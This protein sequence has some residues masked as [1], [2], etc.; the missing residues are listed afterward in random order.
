M[1]KTITAATTTLVTFAVAAAAYMLVPTMQG[2]RLS[3]NAQVIEHLERARRLLVEAHANKERLAVVIDGLRAAGVE[4]LDSDSITELVE[5]DPE[6]LTGAEDQLGAIGQAVRSRRQR[7]QSEANA[8]DDVSL[9][10][11]NARLGNN[12][13]QMAQ[14]ISSG[15]RARQELFAANESVLEE[16]LRE[17][18]AALAAQQG[19]ATGQDDPSALRLLGS[20]QYLQGTSAQRRAEIL[21]QEVTRMRSKLLTLAAKASQQ[22]ALQGIASES[23]I[24]GR[25]AAA[26]ED[27]QEQALHLGELKTK[28]DSINTIIADLVA[29]LA[30]QNSI[31]DAARAK[32]DELALRDLP[33]GDAREYELFAA[34]YG[35]Q[36][37]R[38]RDALGKALVIEFGT[39]DNAAIDRSGDFLT[40][41]YLPANDSMAVE[42]RWGLTHYRDEAS[43]LKVQMAELGETVSSLDE[44]IHSMEETRQA[45]TQQGESAGGSLADLASQITLAL[46]EM[47]LSIGD[48]WA[49]EDE[50]LDK[51]TQAQGAFRRAGQSFQ[52][53]QNDASQAVSAGGVSA[54]NM[55]QSLVAGDRWSKAS[56]EAR[57]ADAQL[58]QA[59]VYYARYRDLTADQELF[60][61]MGEYQPA[62]TDPG[63]LAEDLAT[64]KDAGLEAASA[65]ADNLFAAGSGMQQ[66]F[67]L[68]AGIAA[69]YGLQALFG[70]EDA[71][72]AAMVNY[73]AAIQG[74]EDSPYIRQYAERLEQLR[75]I[76]RTASN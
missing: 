65:A 36:S 28:A 24:D 25:I 59:M 42:P 6:L 37:A 9:P 27:R 32:L 74:R 35:Q 8:P 34:H 21:R 7:L 69:A 57:E 43:V 33:P 39:L 38:Y 16:A 68:T 49:L 31:A 51:L 23:G 18:Q 71:A 67:A 61:A 47:E 29:A 56:S 14:S 55:P 12:A 41:D 50:A 70:E 1:S 62:N 11:L 48:A 52:R 20:I 40:G 75:R 2:D 63:A 60:S 66:H 54:E 64:A 13:P 26:K 4:E 15:I 30:E 53:I 45:L 76:Q 72:R 58:R 22:Q 46:G 73:E 3:V 5:G 10:T 17:A 44:L 19:D